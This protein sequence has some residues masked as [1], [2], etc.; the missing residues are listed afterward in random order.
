[1]SG[2]KSAE[3]EYSYFTMS[4]S[5]ESVRGYHRQLL[6]RLLVTIMVSLA[7]TVSL[8]VLYSR[9]FGAGG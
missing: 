5:D 2:Q 1:M 8:L 7:T 9:L 6:F 4:L 3:S